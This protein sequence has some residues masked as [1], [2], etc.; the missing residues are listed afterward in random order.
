MAITILSSTNGDKYPVSIVADW[1]HVIPHVDITFASVNSTFDPTNNIYLESLGILIAVPGFWLILTLLAFLVFFL[2]RCCDS[3]LRKKRR[4]TP[5]KWTLALF[6]LFCCGALSLGLFGNDQVHSGV[7][8]VQRAT[9]NMENIIDSV[10]N[11]SGVVE[12]ALSTE[13]GPE[14]EKLVTTLGRGGSHV[15]DP[16][17]KSRLDAALSSLP[18]NA[19]LGA[20][21]VRSIYDK[22]RRLDLH[23]LP[24]LLHWA[25]IIRWPATIALLCVL[26]LVCLILLWGVVRHSRCLLILFS[27]LGLLSVVLCWVLVS[28][29]LGICVAG[30]DFCLDPEPFIYKQSGGTAEAAVI[31]YYLNCDEKVV[32]PFDTT[33]KEARRAVDNVQSLLQVV[34][35][36]ADRY[37]PQKEVHELL[38]QLGQQVNGTTRGLGRL[39]ALVDCRGLNVEYRAAMGATCTSVLEGTGFMLVSAAGAGLLFTVLIWVASHTWIHIRQRRPR[40]PVDEEDPFLPPSAVGASSR[41]SRDTNGRSASREDQAFLQAARFTPPPA[42]DGDLTCATK[43]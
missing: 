36:I 27:V 35:R 3:G 15:P 39:A 13:V 19:S 8:S 16:E 37:I 32:S 26:I 34:T 43:F 18:G 14:L 42:H 38:G 6:A 9:Q 1:F 40:E 7:V 4:L 41:R 29:Y 31:S 23:S 17:T 11:E 12:R 24:Y 20:D 2:C 5:L 30:S 22:I 28:L 10:K 25:E 33:V 21:R